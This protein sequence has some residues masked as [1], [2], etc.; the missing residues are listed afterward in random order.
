MNEERPRYRGRVLVVED[1]TMN[2]MVICKVLESMGLQVV[3]ANNGQES[4]DLLRAEAFDVV[5]MDGQMPVMDGYEATRII[6]S[7]AVDG[8][9]SAIPVIALTAH[10]MSGEDQRC[11]DAGMNDYLTKPLS[12]EKLNS[13]LAKYL[14]KE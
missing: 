6:R 2:Q 3:V 5:L 1:S 13:V 14:A 9:N 4:I 10:A 8:I 7:G 11:Y 12:R